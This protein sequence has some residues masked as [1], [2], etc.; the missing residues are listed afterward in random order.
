MISLRQAVGKD[1]NGSSKHHSE[2]IP[3]IPASNLLFLVGTTVGERLLYPC[4][5][6]WAPQGKARAWPV[7]ADSKRRVFKARVSSP[8]TVARLDLKACP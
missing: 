1:L 8:G 3:F 5:V 2:V 6:G 4:T 7:A